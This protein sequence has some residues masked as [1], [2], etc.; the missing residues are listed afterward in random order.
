MPCAALSVIQS[1]FD[2]VFNFCSFKMAAIQNISSHEDPL[3]KAVTKG[4][5]A[6]IVINNDKSVIILRIHVHCRECR[7]EKS[8]E[9]VKKENNNYKI[10]KNMFFSQQLK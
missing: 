4:E 7:N 6:Q 9:T 1:D 2:K 5:L 3:S 10:V 8:D